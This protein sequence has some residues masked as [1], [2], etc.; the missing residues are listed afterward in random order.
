MKNKLNY[1]L[2]EIK[3]KQ[4]LYQVHILFR[5]KI[6]DFSYTAFFLKHI[7]KKKAFYHSGV[8]LA[9]SFPVC[10]FF[11]LKLKNSNHLIHKFYCSKNKTKKKIISYFVSHVN[12]INSVSKSFT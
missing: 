8:T 2:T 4:T 6:K 1:T 9:S 10:F 7:I 5:S 11:Q 12:A 3:I